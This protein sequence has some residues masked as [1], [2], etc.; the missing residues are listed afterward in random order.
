MRCV[1]GRLSF[2]QE[3]EV[4]RNCCQGISGIQS[5]F[6]SWSLAPP[7]Q[8]PKASHVSAVQFDRRW[9]RK[10]SISARVCS[11]EH[12]TSCWLP[13]LAGK[14]SGTGEETGGVVSQAG[15]EV[16]LLSSGQA[17]APWQLHQL[18]GTVSSSGR[19]S[20]DTCPGG[21]QERVQVK[22]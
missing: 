14:S 17:A 20:G 2:L 6:L 15:V 22:G 21:T 16:T 3:V 11:G 10:E 4:T 13:P 18:S 9:W 7:G 1:L 12:S 8:V 5:W 19:E